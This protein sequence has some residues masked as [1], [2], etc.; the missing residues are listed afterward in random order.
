M[1]DNNDTDT[2]TRKVRH[3]VVIAI[4]V[5]K[6]PR[7]LRPLQGF[8]DFIREQGVVGLAI[9]LVLGT[10]IKQLVDQFVTSFANPLL[11]LVLPGKGDLAQ[12]VFT[13]SLSGKT[14]QEFKWGA[15]AAQFISFLVVAAVVYYVVKALKLD[16][17]DKKKDTKNAKPATTSKQ[18]KPNKKK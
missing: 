14:P 3:E 12:K 9:G 17:I 6:V 5:V 11:G 16:K 18:A 4:P 8:V 1:A 7:V 15:F 13:V 10:Q 2:R